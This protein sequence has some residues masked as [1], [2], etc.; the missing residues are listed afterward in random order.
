LAEQISEVKVLHGFPLRPHSPVLL[1]RRVGLIDKVPV[2]Q[3]PPRIPL[4][5]PF[6]PSLPEHDWSSL[7]DYTEEGHQLLEAE[8]Y[9]SQPE[10]IQILD[11]VYAKFVTA[12]EAQISSLTDTPPQGQIHQGHGA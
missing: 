12:M 9:P 11:Q 1:R 7:E 5:I 3:M 10:R 4:H 6:G 2:L 8:H